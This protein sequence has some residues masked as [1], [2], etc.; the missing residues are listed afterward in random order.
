MQFADAF[1][2]GCVHYVVTDCRQDGSVF[3]IGFVGSEQFVEEVATDTVLQLDELH[4]ADVVAHLQ[5]HQ[6]AVVD[7]V[8]F[9]ELRGVADQRLHVAKFVLRLAELRKI[10]GI[11]FKIFENAVQVV[12]AFLLESPFEI[13]LL[14]AEESVFLIDFR[15]H[16]RVADVGRDDVVVFPDGQ[17]DESE[18]RLIDEGAI[19]IFA[20]QRGVVVHVGGHAVE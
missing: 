10:L 5:E 17:P 20:G 3:D 14:I 11:F 12:E 2:Q 18:T 13:L 8:A 4:V 15:R 1:G 9:L 19:R 7:V 6:P 16:A